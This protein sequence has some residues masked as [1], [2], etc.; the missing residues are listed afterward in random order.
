MWHLVENF[1]EQGIIVKLF[2]GVGWLAIVIML[3]SF[4]T[5]VI[6]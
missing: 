4:A 2:I 3:A 1:F 6:P 5:L